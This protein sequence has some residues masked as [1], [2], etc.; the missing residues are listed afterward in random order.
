MSIATCCF[1]FENTTIK[2]KNRNIVS[3][4]AAIKYKNITLIF[5]IRFIQTI[6]NSGGRRL[7]NNTK[8]LESRNSSRI[9]SCLSLRI[10]EISRYSND[11]FFQRMTEKRFGSFFKT[12]NNHCRNFFR[13]ETLFL[14]LILNIN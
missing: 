13:M 14:F 8:N 6:S 1:Y 3:T 5:I 2:C 10:I 9:F 4:S 12:L 7:V 11:N